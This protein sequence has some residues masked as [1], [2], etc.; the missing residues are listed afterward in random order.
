MSGRGGE[1]KNGVGT[2]SAQRCVVLQ[3]MGE[4]GY[5][6]GEHVVWVSL[7]KDIITHGD[8]MPNTHLKVCIPQETCRGLVNFASS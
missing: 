8:S 5:A 7:G 6:T 1:G 2:P 4:G 3:G